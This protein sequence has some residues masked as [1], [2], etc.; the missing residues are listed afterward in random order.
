MHLNKSLFVII[1]K[2]NVYE[3]NIKQFYVFKK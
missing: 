2:T 1:V 3:L